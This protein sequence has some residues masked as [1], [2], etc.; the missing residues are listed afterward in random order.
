MPKAR[1]VMAAVPVVLAAMTGAVAAWGP[2]PAPPARPFT[3]GLWGDLP[4][5]KAGDG[6]KMAALIAD[7]NADEGLAFTAFDGDIKDGTSPCGDD[8]YTAAID[9]F[10]QFEAPT[11]Y[12][13]GD[14]E[15]TDCHRTNNGGY[16]NL[17][18]LAH[19][20]RVMFA[21][22]DSFGR[23]RMPLVHQG[24]PGEAYVENTRW[25]L[26]GVVFAGINVPGSNNN[27]VNDPGGPECSDQSVRRQS[28]C[29]ADNAEYRAR[30]AADIDWVR[31]AFAEA[32]R[33]G[34]RAVMVIMQADPGF[35]LPETK[36]VNER[37]DPSFDGYTDLIGA[38]IEA[39]KAFAG[40]V[41][42]VHGDTHFFKLDKPLV[43]QAHLIPNFTRLETFG[44][45]NVDWV[46]VT[47]DPRSRNS[48]TFEPMV[49]AA[50]KR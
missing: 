25:T 32:K 34:A 35:D 28:Q 39:T 50:D 43:D 47:A 14:N 38:L 24:R 6:P 5:A 48:F 49:I 13:P 22:P 46:K 15:W 20:R 41:V 21:G 29:D 36:T 30:S 11:V 7:M 44:S 31:Q 27:R 37:N 23:R 33:T 16:D 26:G 40:Q 3:F 2:D 9:R 45:P 17:E 42:L 18:R 4:Y 8:Q 12:V 1:L 10:N 19:L